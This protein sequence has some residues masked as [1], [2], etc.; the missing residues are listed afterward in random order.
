[1]ITSLRNDKRAATTHAREIGGLPPLRWNRH[2]SIAPACR[3]I[4]WHGGSRI[5]NRLAATPDRPA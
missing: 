3:Y 1:M 4:P 5:P 2:P